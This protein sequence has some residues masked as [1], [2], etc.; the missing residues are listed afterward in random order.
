MVPILTCG[1]FRSNFSRAA[2]T[3]SR[4]GDTPPP[5]PLLVQS[6]IEDDDGDDT[7]SPATR[8]SWTR[9]AAELR[10]QLRPET[11]ARRFTTPRRPSSA[12]PPL[13]DAEVEDDTEEGVQT[14]NRLRAAQ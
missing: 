7:R 9:A 14:A 8:L 5:P 4:C 12:P 1:F 13:Q 2:R 3:R 10:Q 6:T 11:G